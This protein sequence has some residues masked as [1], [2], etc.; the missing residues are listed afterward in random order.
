MKPVCSTDEFQDRCEQALM[1]AAL[2][3]LERRELARLEAAMQ[4]PQMQAEIAASR[5]R[6]AEATIR[7]IRQRFSRQR[8][9]IHR[10][11]FSR[12]A[13]RTAAVIGALC[14][15]GTGTLSAALANDTLRSKV[16][17]FIQEQSDGR[18]R[19]YMLPDADSTSA[20][21]SEEDSL[22]IV[23]NEWTGD[24]YPSRVPA[25]FWIRTISEF[26]ANVAYES[27]D[28]GGFLFHEYTPGDSV[29]ITRN[30]RTTRREI[31][32]YDCLICEFDDGTL[33]VSWPVEDRF[34]T[35]DAWRMSKDDVCDIVAGIRKIR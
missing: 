8:C 28:G 6:I 18:I 9:Q 32:G 7:Q 5:V 30:A 19:L 13:L 34:F 1:E 33:N 29:E 26:F 17:R 11:T 12:M 27:P 15:L 22:F 24:Y 4:E 31:N 3:E 23:P 16:F 35:L 25:G 14:I 20:L 21:A 10:R 2:T